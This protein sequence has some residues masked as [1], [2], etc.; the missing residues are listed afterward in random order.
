MSSVE[1]APAPGGP[2][3][4]APGDDG[5]TRLLLVHRRRLLA[6]AV[7]G[8]LGEW[9][10]LRLVGVADDPDEALAVVAERRADLVLVDAGAGADTVL[11]TLHALRRAR[12][13]LP[14]LTF[15][16]GDDAEVLEAIEAG[17]NGY[18]VRSAGIDE[19]A[20]AV[21][22]LLRG[23]APCDPAVAARVVERIVRLCEDAEERPPPPAQALTERELEVLDLVAA[24]LA[25]KEIAGRLEIAVST[26]KNHVHSILDKL[27]VGKRRAAVQVAYEH[28]IIDRYL[29]HRSPGERCG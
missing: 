1:G 23:R 6:E 12:G 5:P 15:G 9:P 20:A 2:L 28:G 26:V 18:L 7:V 14:I 16:L 11:D 17:S 22:S 8:A 3:A 19:L 25:N 24:G 27:G 10:G 21:D 13:D 29:P 4:A